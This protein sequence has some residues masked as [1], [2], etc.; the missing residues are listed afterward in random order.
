[1]EIILAENAGFCYGV[2]RA[3]K[4]VHENSSKEKLFT[5]GPLIHNKTVIDDFEKKGVKV[6]NCLDEVDSGTVIIRAHG[7]EKEDYLKLEEKNLEYIDCTC[8]H[9][10]RI[11]KIVEEENSSGRQIII[12]GSEVHPEIIGIKSFSSEGVEVVEKLEDLEKIDFNINKKYSIVVQTTFIQEKFDKI[13]ETIKSKNADI[14]VFDTICSA[15]EKRQ[16]EAE[17]LSKNVDI[18]IILGDKGSSNTAK[19]YEICKKNCKNTYLVETIRDLELNISCINGKIGI[20]AGAS[21]PPEIIKEAF[22]TMSEH[23]NTNSEQSFEEMI[24]NESLVF[25]RTGDVVKGT[26]ISVQNGDISVNLN[27]KSD[28]IIPRSEFSE[29]PDINPA[30]EVKAGDEINVF[31]VRVNDGDGNVLLSKKKV[32][33][34]RNMDEIEEA[35]NN[36]LELKG[37]IIDIVK[38]GLIANIKGVRAFVPSSQISNRFTEDLKQFKGKE[39]IFKILEFDKNKRRVVA[40]RKELAI[41]EQNEIKLKVFDTL[42]VGQKVSGVVSRIVDFGAFVDLGGVDGLIHISK[43]SWGRVKNV[44]EILKENDTVTTVVLEIDKEKDKISLSL[45]D[46]NQDPWK[47]VSEKYSIGDIVEGKVVRMVPFGAF[48]ELIE[49]V[50]G[51]VHISQISQKHIAKPEEALQIG[52]CISAKI[53]EIDME[54]KR[55]SLSIKETEDVGTEEGSSVE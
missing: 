27:Y 11:H 30:D 14:K 1:M 20:T 10:K 36:K 44:R 8:P 43:L 52:Q 23:D 7:I 48:V 47:I 29:D 17:Y 41:R 26:V 5:Y 25:L 6:I 31:V 15:T 16:K 33:S 34:R 51:L 42:E 24:S 32:E 38:G 49:G 40:G 4:T 19:L 45:K 21:T 55:I 12:V 2:D 50:D 18:M 54:N 37:K 53:I 22:I 46:I 39:F 13:V 3:V 28:G 9:V 35:F